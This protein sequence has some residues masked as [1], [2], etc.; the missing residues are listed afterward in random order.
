MSHQEKILKTI[1]GGAGA[2][3]FGIRRVKGSKIDPNDKSGAEPEL[4]VDVTVE[5][6]D[7]DKN[8]DIVS[9]IE[10][11]FGVKN[12]HNETCDPCHCDNPIP[13]SCVGD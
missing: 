2:T 10:N 7:L 9:S 11:K 4:E 5:K 13:P 8:S 6:V 3:V 1:S 12:I